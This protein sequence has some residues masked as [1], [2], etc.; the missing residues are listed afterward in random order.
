MEEK[1]LTL[2]THRVKALFLARIYPDSLRH[3]PSLAGSSCD[4]TNLLDSSL[5]MRLVLCRTLA[6]SSYIMYLLSV[7]ARN[8]YVHGSLL[9][10][11]HLSPPFIAVKSCFICKCHH[12]IY[13]WKGSHSW[14]SMLQFKR[15][16]WLYSQQVILKQTLLL[17]N[18]FLLE[19]CWP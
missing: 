16:A 4:A 13:S 2:L 9:T 17:I 8:H 5:S 14:N 7:Q 6:G 12:V 18:A 3:P 1:N 10:S 15:G 19:F 11:W